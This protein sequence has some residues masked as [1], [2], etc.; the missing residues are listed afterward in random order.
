MSFS[1]LRNEKAIKSFFCTLEKASTHSLL[2]VD[3]NNWTLYV[4]AKSPINSAKVR[5]KPLWMALSI[6]SIHKIPFEQY[7]TSNAISKIRCKP[8]PYFVKSKLWL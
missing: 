6:S 7:V 4:F 2:C 8:S 5:N 3:R 1:P